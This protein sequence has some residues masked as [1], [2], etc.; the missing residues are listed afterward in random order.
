MQHTKGKKVNFDMSTTQETK[1]IKPHS[2]QT[3]I[4]Y[5]LHRHTTQTHIYEIWEN[6]SSVDFW[7]KIEKKS[8]FFC[9]LSLSNSLVFSFLIS[10][11]FNKMSISYGKFSSYQTKTFCWINANMYWNKLQETQIVYNSNKMHQSTSLTIIIIVYVVV[12]N[13]MFYWFGLN[14]ISSCI[15]CVDFCIAM[16]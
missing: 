1:S 11:P 8:C 12:N 4:Q 10:Q 6:W 14:V 13:F 2:P 7:V 5:T 16:N 9:F 3:N 15:I